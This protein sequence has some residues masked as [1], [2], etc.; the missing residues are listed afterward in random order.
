M[1]D[2]GPGS[3]VSNRNKINNPKDFHSVTNILSPPRPTS[4]IS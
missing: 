1:K 2:S 3:K 4:N